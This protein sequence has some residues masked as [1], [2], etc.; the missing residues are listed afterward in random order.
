MLIG[1]PRKSL[2]R[3]IKNLKKLAYSAED[4]DVE[5][6]KWISNVDEYPYHVIQEV[7]PKN[8]KEYKVLKFN[9]AKIKKDFE[10]D[11]YVK[12]LEDDEGKI[13]AIE[14]NMER[15]KYLGEVFDSIPFGILN[16]N[17]TGVG[18]TT[19]EIEAKRNSIIVFPNKSL[20]YS[21]SKTKDSL[22]Y[23]GS[24]IG[25]ITSS[26]FSKDIKK[27]IDEIDQRR[28]YEE[29]VYKK[30]LVVADSLPK[31]YEVI[32]TKKEFFESYFLLVDEVDMI[33]SD[34]T[35]RPKLEDVIDY[36]CK[37]PQSNRALV[38]AT[39]RD[40]THHEVQKEPMLIAKYDNEEERQKPHQI[41]HT[42]NPNR[43]VVEY[44]K[45]RYNG[46]KEK[47]VIAYNSITDIK[48]II[49]LLP[50][51]LRSRCGVLCS[52]ESEDKVKDYYVELVD[53]KLEKDITFMTCVYFVGVDIHERYQLVSV[54]NANVPYTLLS[55]DRLTQIRGRCRHED[56]LI[57]E[58]ICYSTK[59]DNKYK[60]GDISKEEY[61]DRLLKK[62]DKIIQLYHAIDNIVEEEQDGE[63][64]D[65]FDSLFDKVKPAIQRYATEKVGNLE[66]SLSRKDID[67][68]YQ[69]SYFNIDALVEMFDLLNNLY[70][71]K[72]KLEGK[73]GLEIG[74]TLH[75][76]ITKEQEECRKKVQ[77]K[78]KMRKDELMAAAKEKILQLH[79]ER[80]LT[81]EEIESLK[82]EKGQ[83]D[84]ERYYDGVKDL[85]EYVKINE[86]LS[87]LDEDPDPREYR[88]YKNGVMFKALDDTNPFK[89]ALLA[90]FPV[91]ETFHLTNDIRN[92]MSQKVEECLN[93]K[94]D[95]SKNTLMYLFRSFFTTKRNRY[96][97]GYKIVCIGNR[98]YPDP[99]KTINT[100]KT[101]DYFD[102]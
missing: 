7:N 72:G 34:A 99:I 55:I 93:R 4:C 81:T 61:R 14:F 17:R 39:I 33:Q 102:I 12:R 3:E 28:S 45:E 66:V 69:I 85:H 35:Y 76:E 77:D 54:I 6:P 44:I 84:I 30:F 60:F 41:I 50:E 20:A 53:G 47:I 38:S 1:K 37:F 92:F 24:P 82:D 86:L 13:Q 75:F 100:S 88:N 26:I 58:T 59:E 42:D 25:D 21:K 36:Y 101:Y 79:N 22:L 65:E 57:S 68:N 64:R 48:E 80:R 18:A 56:G 98:D 43:A 8:S 15:K 11:T 73:Y 63:M 32:A 96:G 10:L 95:S 89:A 97:N 5:K 52:E 16:K 31:V 62:A 49:F 91:S 70:D 19:L 94:I 67:K 87:F 23:V 40:F 2:V 71:K 9:G 27:Y 46:E 83:R 51:D 29:D 74:D 78:K 90:K